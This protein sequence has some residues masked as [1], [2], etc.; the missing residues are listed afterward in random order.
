MCLDLL[1]RIENEPDLW[2]SIITCDEIWV[3]MNDPETK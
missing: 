1:H 3:F 2:N